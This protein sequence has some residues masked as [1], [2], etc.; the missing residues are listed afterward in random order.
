MDKTSNVGHIFTIFTVSHFVSPYYINIFVIY[1]SSHTVQ[2]VNDISG[3]AVNIV[4]SIVTKIWG[5]GLDKVEE[6][7]EE[8]EEEEDKDEE[9]LEEEENEEEE[10]EEDELDGEEEEVE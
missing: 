7:Q 2:I 1:I 5:S 8:K 3:H 9:E 6:I 10:N 4:N